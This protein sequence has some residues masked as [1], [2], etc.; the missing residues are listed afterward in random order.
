MLEI[1]ES[2]REFVGAVCVFGGGMTRQVLER[3]PGTYANRMREHEV[4]ER[5]QRRWRE[6]IE[7]RRTD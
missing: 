6:L 5:G 4:S 2:V 1:C 7:S 3:L